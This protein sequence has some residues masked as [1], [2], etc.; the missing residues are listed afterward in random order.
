MTGHVFLLGL[1][2]LVFME[3][4]LRVGSGCLACARAKPDRS[5]SRISSRSRGRNCVPSSFTGLFIIPRQFVPVRACNPVQIVD[6]FPFSKRQLAAELLRSSQSSSIHINKA[7]GA[8]LEPQ[9]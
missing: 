6:H 2:V 5:L 8:F 1:S 9:N 7:E 4:A 3:A